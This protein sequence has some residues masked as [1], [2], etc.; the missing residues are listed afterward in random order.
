MIDPVRAVH[1]AAEEPDPSE[2]EELRALFHRLWSKAATGNPEYVKAEW[3]R[4]AALLA[5]RG[6]RT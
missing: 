1:P 3:K 4:L 6:V 2:A 5:A